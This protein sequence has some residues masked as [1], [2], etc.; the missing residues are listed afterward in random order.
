MT[1]P[2]CG[3]TLAFFAVACP[4]CGNPSFGSLI[5]QSIAASQQ[6]SKP[7]QVTGEEWAAIFKVLMVV[8]LVVTFAVALTLGIM[9]TTESELVANVT[10]KGFVALKWFTVTALAFLPFGIISGLITQSSENDFL[11]GYIWGQLTGPIGL[12]VV[13]FQIPDAKSG[14][15]EPTV[16]HPRR[17]SRQVQPRKEVVKELFPFPC[18]Y[19]RKRYQV[20]KSAEGDWFQCVK[21]GNNIM[22]VITKYAS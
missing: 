14:P 2:T 6:E 16:R 4:H 7:G 19:C 18:P 11:P 5:Q 12:I 3:N 10:Q 8:G 15:S 17:A 1:C 9:W 13:I 21:C 22:V 20:E